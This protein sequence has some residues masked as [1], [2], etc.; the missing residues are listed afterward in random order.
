[1]IKKW[2]AVVILAVKAGTGFALVLASVNSTDIT[3]SSFRHA[4]RS[5]GSHGNLVGEQPELRERFLHHLVDTELK[6][7]AA[8]G[9]KLQESQEFRSRMEQAE[10]QIL[11]N[12]YIEN[13]INS[14]TSDASLASYFE[15]NK[16][17]F[18]RK[19][20]RIS[21][22]FFKDETTATKFLNEVVKV[23]GQFEKIYSKYF[24]SKNAGDSEE[25][26]IEK[27][28]HVINFEKAVFSTPK[29]AIANKV[30]PTNSGYHVIRID[31]VKY[32]EQQK[33]EYF[34]AEIKQF[35]V[36]ELQEKLIQELK[37][38]AKVNVNTQALGNF[39][40]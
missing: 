39:S 26:W 23:P 3:D 29:G 25:D 19:A 27:G 18:T 21:Y 17:V 35:R 36:R 30:I 31:D 12:L 16:E 34:K 11:A 5:L 24:A 4:L 13:H 22:A 1:M 8:I 9:Q 7:Q 38:S 10:R 2:L 37:A 32:N 15:A 28:S 40:L 20:V 33:F 14:N 6:A